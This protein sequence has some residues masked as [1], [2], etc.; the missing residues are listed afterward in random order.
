MGNNDP[1]PNV[2]ITGEWATEYMQKR[3]NHRRKLIR[4]VTT[5]VLTDPARQTQYDRSP[6]TVAYRVHEMV[7]AILNATEP[8]PEQR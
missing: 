6:E 4:V 3:T 2:I 5:A 7:T 8:E 1:I